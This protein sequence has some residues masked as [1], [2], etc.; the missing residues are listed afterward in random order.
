MDLE[1]DSVRGGSNTHEEKGE[2]EDTEADNKEEIIDMVLHVSGTEPRPKVDVR[3]WKDLQEQ[4]KDNITNVYKQNARLTTINWLLLLHNFA[5]L[6]IKG[7][8]PNGCQPGNHLAV[9]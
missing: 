9:A 2:G 5:T 8:W 7:N 6:W 3:P 4:L 1:L